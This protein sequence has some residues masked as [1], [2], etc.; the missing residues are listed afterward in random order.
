MSNLR[1]C[2]VDSDTEYFN[3][4]E[5]KKIKDYDGKDKVLQYIGYGVAEMA[6]PLGY[7]HIESPLPFY[8]Y[9]L[10]PN[11]THICLTSNAIEV[12]SKVPSSVL[13]NGDL[14]LDSRIMGHIHTS[15]NAKEGIFSEKDFSF[16][17][18]SSYASRLE[19]LSELVNEEKYIY[20][21]STSYK[22][23]NTLCSL[24]NW[25][26]EVESFI[27]GI[28]KCKVARPENVCEVISLVCSK[29]RKDKRKKDKYNIQVP[30][31]MVVLRREGNVFISV[32]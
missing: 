1:R 12:N 2:Y 9:T 3:G 13:Y 24:S 7:E 21:S 23:F 31:G 20:L 4:V 8:L 15:L 19:L 29:V 30:S 16:L 6:Y 27:N 22:V 5:W 17:Y 18:S 28:Y 14:N 10:S 32:N 26:L 25:Y 11:N